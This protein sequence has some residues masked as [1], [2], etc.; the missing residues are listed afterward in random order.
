MKKISQREFFRQLIN[1]VSAKVGA[2]RFP[3]NVEMTD[4][5]VMSM[6]AKCEPLKY[7][8]VVHTQTNAIKFE[9]ESWFYFD[10][11]SNC[12]SRKAFRHDIDG[13]VFISLVDHRPAYENMFCNPFPELTMVLIYQIVA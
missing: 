9:D 11:P 6:I 1:G 7:R 8:K 10:K 2:P 4:D 12:D 13:N 5:I 3:G